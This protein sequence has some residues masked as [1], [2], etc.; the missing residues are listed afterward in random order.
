MQADITA[1]HANADPLEIAHF[2]NLASQWWDT[3]GTFR[4]L[5]AIN[6]LRLQ[7]IAAHAT[8]AGSQVLDIGC[9]GGILAQALAQ[10]QAQ[11]TGIDLAQESIHIARQHAQ[12]QHQQHG[13]AMPQY[14]HTS[15]EAL[16]LEGIDTIIACDG[17]IALDELG[18]AIEDL[19][20]TLHRIG[21]CNTPRTA[22]EAMYEGLKVA[23]MI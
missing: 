10:A 5:H 1:T 14:L 16:E 8:L 6:P 17:Q 19:G 23:A 3:Q 20:M 2:G 13:T 21:D 11:V 4:A 18:D 12:E 9:G 7:W 22:E 15:A